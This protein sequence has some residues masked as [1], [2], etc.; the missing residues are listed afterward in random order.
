M[1][2]D[3]SAEYYCLRAGHERALAD[4]ADSDTKRAEH[5]RNAERYE[6]LMNQAVR[7]SSIDRGPDNA[8]TPGVG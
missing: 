7:Q 4:A 1:V 6:A 3:L 2:S 5:L 8:S